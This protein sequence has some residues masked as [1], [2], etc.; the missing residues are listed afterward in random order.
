LKG[1]R[2]KA[3]EKRQKRKGKRE[4]AKEKRQKRKFSIFP[5]V[6]ILPVFPF[7]L[8]PSPYSALT[9]DFSG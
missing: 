1:K 4:K 6:P 9:H 3:K 5:T 2:E 8:S 7:P